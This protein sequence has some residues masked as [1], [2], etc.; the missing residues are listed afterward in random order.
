MPVRIPSLSEYISLSLTGLPTF[1]NYTITYWEQVVTDNAGTNRL[2]YLLQDGSFAAVH[3]IARAGDNVDRLSNNASSQALTANA[4]NSAWVMWALTCAG[5]GATDLK[6]YTWDATDAD[7]AYESA[8]LTGVGAGSLS[9]WWLGSNGAFSEYRNA[10]YCFVKVWD[11]VLTLSE[12][13]AERTQG[14]PVKTASVNRYHRLETNS[15][16]TD[17][18]GNGR[19]LSFG[20]SPTT[21]GTEPVPWEAT[22]ALLFGAAIF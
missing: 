9:A 15:D 17:Y 14:K 11:T 2:S 19:S 21:D 1:T 18:S 5:T 10:R 4:S 6:L 12:L 8:T 13:Q 7:G 22:T 16:T 20:G 3:K